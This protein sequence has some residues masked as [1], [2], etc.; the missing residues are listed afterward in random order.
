MV[1]PSTCILA[2]HGHLPS[3]M[4]TTWNR[5]CLACATST[6]IRPVVLVSQPCTPGHL[7]PEWASSLCF[8]GSDL[9]CAY[10]MRCCVSRVRSLGSIWIP[11]W[12]IL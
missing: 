6:R 7:M 1:Y 10:A 12:H 3:W 11:S 4:P 8:G 2:G 9:G 5:S